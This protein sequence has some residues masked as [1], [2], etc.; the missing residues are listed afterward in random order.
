MSS[1]ATFFLAENLRKKKS[2][3][4]KLGYLIFLERR[5]LICLFKRTVSLKKKKEKR[6]QK[7]DSAAALR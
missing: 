1:L 2:M 4:K 5:V 3:C 7:P 6:N